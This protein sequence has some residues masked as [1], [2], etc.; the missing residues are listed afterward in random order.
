MVDA[1]KTMKKTPLKINGD[2]RK[3]FDNLLARKGEEKPGMVVAEAKIGEHLANVHEHDAAETS[4]AHAAQQWDAVRQESDYLAK[5]YDPEVFNELNSKTGE[6]PAT[7]AENTTNGAATGATPG[8]AG[9]AEQPG[10]IGQGGDNVGAEGPWSRSNTDGSPPATGAESSTA[11]PGATGGATNAAGTGSA[12]EPGT[13]SAATDATGAGGTAEPATPATTGSGTAEQT[14]GPWNSQGEGRQS[15]RFIKEDGTLDKGALNY[16]LYNST[17][18]WLQKFFDEYADKN[19]STFNDP[20]GGVET[21]DSMQ[22]LMKATGWTPSEIRNM[23]IGQK[24]NRLQQLASAELFK[25][26]VEDV[27]EK[28]A[29]ATSGDPKAVA[30]F[31]EA[32]TEH[33]LLMRL[34]RD[35][36]AYSAEASRGLG[37]RRAIKGITGDAEQFVELFQKITD[38][39]PKDIEQQARMLQDLTSPGAAEKFLKDG[40]QTRWQ[41]FRNGMLEYYINALISGPITHFRYSVGNLANAL[42]TPLLEIPAAATIGYAREIL[43]GDK[44]IDRV[45]YGEAGAQLKG[46]FNGSREGLRSAYQAW[47][48]GN[49]P[50][51]PG[52]RVSDLFLAK[53]QQGNAIPGVVGDILNVPS[54]SVSAIHSFFKSIRYEQEINSQAYRTATREGLNGADFDRRVSDLT[55]NPTDDMMNMASSKALRELFMAPTEYKGFMGKITRATNENM[56]AKIIVPFMKIGTQITR[57]AFMDRTP[58]GLLTEEGRANLSYAKGGAEGD[59]AIGKIA[60][61]TALIATTSAMVLEGVATGDGPDDPKQNAIWRLNHRP[62]TITIGNVTIPYQ[63]LGP[64]GMLMRFSANMTETAKMNSDKG[65]GTLAEGFFKGITKAVLDENFMRGVKDALDA[66]YHWDEYGPNYLRSFATNWLPFSVG[67]SQVDKASIFGL[68]P[69]QD[70]YL[71]E[72]N[73]NNDYWTQ[74]KQS[75]EI[76]EPLLSENLKPRFD[77]FGQPIPTNTN[78]AIARYKDDPTVAKMEELQIGMSRVER[79]ILGVPLND[80]QLA[81]YESKSGIVAKQYLDRLISNPGF[82]NLSKATQIILINKTVETARKDARNIVLTDPDHPENLD[83]MRQAVLNKRKDILGNTP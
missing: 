61:G 7:P 20:T 62:N 10:A 16:A 24:R 30:A 70:P 40:S 13:A 49:S 18:D 39:A 32:T 41:K 38:K 57:N 83:I 75:A 79:K 51:L 34:F 67:T 45:Y 52:E 54:H 58:L 1:Y 26:V 29:A 56:A 15:G 22:T 76:K 27:K 17:P 23:E 66:V 69:V 46:L 21:L 53:Q 80:D 4:P 8:E 71:R 2:I 60:V 9:T 63:G 25:Q 12:A 3:V 6:Q 11:E 72:V 43:T 74:L 77:R 28:S 31:Y 36:Q 68:N 65:L 50:A 47:K 42:A 35:Q 73:L 33:S 64:L 78:E 14:S 48:T 55:M 5:L 59:L 82:V 37:I 81:Q 19:R 44:G